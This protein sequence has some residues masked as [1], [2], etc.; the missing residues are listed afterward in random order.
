MGFVDYVRRSPTTRH[1]LLVGDVPYWISNRKAGT[2]YISA[3]IVSTPPWVDVSALR[4]LQAQAAEI[5]Q[6]TGVLHVL[7]HIVPIRHPRVCGLTVPWNLQIIT[8]LQNN[9]KGNKW[10]PE[11]TEMFE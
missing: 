5:T 3:I 4:A 8:N 7:D 10:C 11:Q 9:S 6:R 1:R 2:G